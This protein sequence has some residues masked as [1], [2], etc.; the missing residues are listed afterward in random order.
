LIKIAPITPNA[1]KINFSRFAP[2]AKLGMQDAAEAAVADFEQTTATWQHKPTFTA[3]EQPTG[4]LVGTDD[5]V[6]SMLDSGTRA[7]LIVA[8]RAKRL[9]FATGGTP[10]T[11][12][13][14]VGSQSGSV[15]RGA[16]VFA[17]AVQH[18]GTKARSWSKLIASKYRVQVSRYIAVRIKEAV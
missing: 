10:K 1:K 15:G 17:R 9:R 18:P 6:W 4:F 8:R 16:P 12:P 11:R 14:F 3:K 13:G 7:H 5:D 2:A